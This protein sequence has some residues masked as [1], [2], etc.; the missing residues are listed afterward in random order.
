MRR[1]HTAVILAVVAVALVLPPSLVAQHQPTIAQ[2]L[3]PGMPVELVSAD[4]VD[5]IAW[6]AYEEGKRNVYTA[7]GPAFRPVRVTSFLTDDGVDMTQLRI[8]DDGSTVAFVRGSGP[9]GDGWNANPASD[10][11]GP[12]RAIWAARTATPGSAVRLAE[13]NSP[14]V[15]PDGRFVLYVKD[16]QIYRARVSQ[17]PVTSPID[18]GEKAFIEAWGRNSAPH[19]SPDGSKILFSSNRNDHSF[20]GLYDVKTRTLSYLAPSVDR[21]TSPTWSPDGKHVA[22]L[23]RPGLPFGL[24]DSPGRGS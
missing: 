10:P 23:R 17:A 20:I 24:Q 13:G 8:S 15:S 14:E 5:R 19:W 1:L 22:F 6:I 3:K 12:E 2:Y 7:A 21:D 18:K 16:G 4:K 11:N 9:N